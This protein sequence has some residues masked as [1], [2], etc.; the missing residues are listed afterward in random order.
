MGASRQRR[1]S[2]GT[3]QL[4][5]FFGK[6]LSMVARSTGG[7]FHVGGDHDNGSGR[8]AGVCRGSSCD[9]ADG[10]GCGPSQVQFDVTLDDAL[11]VPAQSA[12]GKAMVTVFEGDFTLAWPPRKAQKPREGSSWSLRTTPKAGFCFRLPLLAIRAP[13]SRKAIVACSL[14]EGARKSLKAALFSGT[15]KLLESFG[16]FVHQT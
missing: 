10:C 14:R 5:F 1:L 16:A 4:V 9:G 11:H 7:A 12:A 2:C 3:P 6:F 8:S 13:R 15:G